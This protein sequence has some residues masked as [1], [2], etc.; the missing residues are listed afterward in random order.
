ME[1]RAAAEAGEIVVMTVPFA[2]QQATLAHV[3]EAVQGKIFIDVTV[4]LKP[5]K[6]GTVQLP[7]EGSAGVICQQT[8]GDEVKVVSAFQNIAAAHLDSDHKVKCDVL[9]TGNNKEARQVVIDL[10]QSIG[11]KAWHAGPIANS[12]ATEALTSVLITLNR[13]YKIPGAGIVIT[14]EP[15]A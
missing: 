11:L 1:N 2:H 5:P 9:V 7:A 13:Q 4:A 12:A 15:G 8:L 6:V 14:G 10:A 3:R